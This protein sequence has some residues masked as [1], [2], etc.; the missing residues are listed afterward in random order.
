LI[1]HKSTKNATTFLWLI[2]FRNRLQLEAFDANLGK[3]KTSFKYLDIITALFVAVL[4]ISNIAS[5]KIAKVGLLTLDGG[6]LLFPLTYIFGDVLTEVYGYGRSRRVIWLGFA[7]AVLMSLTF[8]VIGALPSANGWDN[9]TAYLAILGQTPRI[10]AASLAAYFV[11]EFSNSFILAKMKILTKGKWLW[12]R[13][14]GST[15]V[16][17]LLDSLIFVSIAFIGVLPRELILE[18]IVANYLFKTSIEIV[19]TPA[20]YLIVGFLKKR[21]KEDYYD[22]KTNFSPFIAEA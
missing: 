9:Q 20:T 17:E 15:L 4:L 3:M 21:E 2:Q 19:F 16:G 1:I 11:G 12:M 8:Y 6:T 22:R 7:G 18:L 5:T 10:V 14:I 13:T